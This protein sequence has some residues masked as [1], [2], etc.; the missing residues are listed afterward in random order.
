MPGMRGDELVSAIRK[1]PKYSVIPII[2]LSAE[3][4]VGSVK[5]C[6]TAG[7]NDYIVKPLDD[8]KYF[9]K[10]KKFINLDELENA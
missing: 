8:V 4:T 1:I 3:N 6:L 9:E 10:I 7:A 2:I 5:S